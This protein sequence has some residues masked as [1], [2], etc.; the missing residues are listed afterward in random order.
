M[1]LRTNLFTHE[2]IPALPTTRPKADQCLIPEQASY[3]QTCNSWVYRHSAPRIL[4]HSGEPVPLAA[5]RVL[6]TIL[7]RGQSG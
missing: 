6:V 5:N 1:F 3:Q 4:V 7:A 2:T